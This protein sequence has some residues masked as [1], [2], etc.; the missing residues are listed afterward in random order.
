ML[1]HQ[2]VHSESKEK[3]RQKQHFLLHFLSMTLISE[4]LSSHDIKAT[5]CCPVYWVV[6]KCWP[7]LSRDRAE[8]HQPTRVVRYI[9]LLQPLAVTGAPLLWRQYQ[10]IGDMYE[11]THSRPRQETCAT[12]WSPA[13]EPCP[14]NTD[15]PSSLSKGHDWEGTV[16]WDT[17][18]PKPALFVLIIAGDNSWQRWQFKT[19]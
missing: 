14:R 19:L 13:A 15:P 8:W 16:T 7:T 3:R 9:N 4:S 11:D 17:Q 12:L 6:T 1:C 10:P 18:S 5:L 2:S